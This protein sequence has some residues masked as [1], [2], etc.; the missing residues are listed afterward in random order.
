MG[1][2]WK[3]NGLGYL[4]MEISYFLNLVLNVGEY[5]LDKMEVILWFFFKVMMVVEVVL[6]WF[7]EYFLFEVFDFVFIFENNVLYF[8]FI[9]MVNFFLLEILFVFMNF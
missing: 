5:V 8:I 6:D 1:L 3:R 9:F 2:I 4:G 7:F